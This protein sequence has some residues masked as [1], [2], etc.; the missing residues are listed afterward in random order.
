MRR[1]AVAFHPRAEQL[2]AAEDGIEGIERAGA[3]HDQHLGP[4]AS[5]G[6]QLVG[7]RARRG[8]GIADRRQPATEPVDLCLSADSKRARCLASRFSRATA[9]TV[10]GRKLFTAR[11]PRAARAVRS[12]LTMVCS[13]MTNGV[14]FALPTVSPGSTG[15]PSN[16][17]NTETPSWTLTATSASRGMERSPRRVAASVHCPPA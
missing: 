15:C 4:L 17:V 10:I 2:E 16:S 7:D 6:Q 5:E 3:G 9:P 1:R 14:T 13:A 12:T 8:A 11:S